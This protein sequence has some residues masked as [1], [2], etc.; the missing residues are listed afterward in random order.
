MLLSYFY[1]LSHLSILVLLSREFY[2]TSEIS[3]K[4]SLIFGG[5]ELN[6]KNVR[7]FLLIQKTINFFKN[8]FLREN[9]HRVS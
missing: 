4:V 2:R 8:I 7:Y 1:E 5:K 6:S 9:I 3:W